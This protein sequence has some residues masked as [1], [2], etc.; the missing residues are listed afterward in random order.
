MVDFFSKN[1]II[2][3]LVVATILLRQAFPLFT[4]RKIFNVHN[5]D[6]DC[7]PLPLPLFN[8]FSGNFGSL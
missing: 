4:L 1:D 8:I 2:Q 3:Q 5:S 7:T 6:L